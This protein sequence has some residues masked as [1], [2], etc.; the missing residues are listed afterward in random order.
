ME[1]HTLKEKDMEL[2]SRK[3]VTLVV[4]NETVTPSRLDLLK[5]ISKKF[6]TKED[7][8]I[9]KHIYPQFG[10]KKTKVIVH[11]YKD[12]AKMALFEHKNLI[13]K[14]KPKVAKVAAE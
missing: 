4:D 5:A 3:R 2:L 10:I 8:V 12:E 6:N 13:S 14:H 11:L 1:L 9:I 7:L